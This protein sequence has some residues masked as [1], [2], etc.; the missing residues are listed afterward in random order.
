MGSAPS[1]SPQYIKRSTHIHNI[2]IVGSSWAR[3]KTSPC[4]TMSL[5]PS[6]FRAKARPQ[7]SSSQRLSSSRNG[8][9]FSSLALRIFPVI[10]RRRSDVKGVVDAGVGSNY[11][12]LRMRTGT[13]SWHA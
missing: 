11:L 10:Q 9:G 7:F 6:F 5:P 4:C 3:A 13:F 2:Y 12:A 1:L 8:L